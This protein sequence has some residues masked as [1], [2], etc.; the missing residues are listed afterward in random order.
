MNVQFT[1]VSLHLDSWGIKRL[2]SLCL[3][4]WRRDIVTFRVPWLRL[5]DQ[6][7]KLGTPTKTIWTVWR[8]WRCL[9]PKPYR[10]HILES[11]VVFQ[12]SIFFSSVLGDVFYLHHAQDPN[13]RQL[14]NIMA[15]HWTPTDVV[16]TGSGESQDSSTTPPSTEVGNTRVPEGTSPGPTTPPPAN[17]LELEALRLQRESVLQ[18]G[19]FSLM[20]FAFEICNLLWFPF[21]PHTETGLWVLLLCYIFYLFLRQRLKAIRAARHLPPP[22][23]REPVPPCPKGVFWKIRYFKVKSLKSVL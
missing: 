17:F 15:T 1:P 16:D 13:L 20:S 5:N 8:I 10:N 14:M 6:Y 22:E 21:T 23:P 11:K 7:I 3:K 9:L 12:T 18:L 19:Y 4:R 2:I